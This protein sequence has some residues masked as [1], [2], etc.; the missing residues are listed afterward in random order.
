M[1][2]AKYQA[3][4]QPQLSCELI[5]EWW[6]TRKESSLMLCCPQ[7]CHGI[8]LD[9]TLCH[10]WEVLR[11]GR[12]RSLE[13]IDFT[14]KQSMNRKAPYGL[15]N[16]CSE[17]ICVKLHPNWYM[18]ATIVAVL[19]ESLV[20]ELHFS[21]SNDGQLPGLPHWFHRGNV[22]S[23]PCMNPNRWYS[24]GTKCRLLVGLGRSYQPIFWIPHAQMSSE[25]P[26]VIMFQDDLSPFPRIFVILC[27]LKLVKIVSSID[28]QPCDKNSTS[29]H[30]LEF[31]RLLLHHGGLWCFCSSALDLSC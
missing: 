12:T 25:G 24:K 13:E 31:P 19:K 2:S 18:F 6:L 4:L 10:L 9:W 20:I 14:F 15:S 1:N 26:Y 17:F 23:D 21:S 5:V 3:R 29:W 28:S 16:L 8:S 27:T 30:P 11:E 7:I 22:A